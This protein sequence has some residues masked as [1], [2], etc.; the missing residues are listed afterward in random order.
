MYL[1]GMHRE[2]DIENRLVDTVGEGEGG[3]GGESSSETYALP[4][5]KQRASGKFP[6]NTG[7]QPGAL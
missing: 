5:V 1:Q 2:A 7:A 6:H 3:M 4:F